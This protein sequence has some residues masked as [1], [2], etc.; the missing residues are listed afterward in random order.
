MNEKG[1]IVMSCLNGNRLQ[2]VKHIF[3]VM[4]SAFAL[5]LVFSGCTSPLYP[6]YN[7]LDSS[8]FILT[9]KGILEGK[10]CYVDLFDHKGPVLFWLEALGYAMGGRTGVCI[11]QSIFFGIDIL[12]LEKIVKSFEAKPLLPLLGFATV[13]FYCFSHGNLTEE[14]SMPFILIAVYCEVL[15]LKSNKAEHPPI[16]A[17]AYGII[18][19]ILAFLRL[20]NAITMC[21]LIVCTGIALIAAKKWKN[22]IANLLAGLLGIAVAALPIC[23]Y[24][25][26]NNALYD[27]LYA[28]FLYNL[29]YAKES[30][31][32]AIFS[33]E[34]P[35][36]IVMYAPG[37]FATAVF[38][39][40]G[41]RTKSRLYFSLLSATAVTYAM[42]VYTNVYV[43][44]FTLGA[45]LF[46]IAIAVAL[47][48]ADVKNIL[49]F[50]KSKKIAAISATLIVTIFALFSAYSVGAPIY[51]T[52]IS[53][54][55]NQ[56]YNQTHESMQIIPQDERNSVIGFGVLADFYVNADITPCYKYYTLQKWWT[57]EQR[58]VYGEFLEYVKNDEPLWIVTNVGEDDREMLNLLENYTIVVQD[59]YYTYYRLNKR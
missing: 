32:S 35:F 57:T 43:H 53:G 29:I 54:I 18:I 31:H 58:N 55:S 6:H 17:F 52:Y 16:L 19:G 13:F 30:T 38:A 39:I 40:A 33:A 15:F 28:T 8:I 24:Y 14:L 49:S 21:V 12:V 11:L 23:W 22:I 41:K 45:P 48:D 9:G 2:S 42:L 59:D 46:A 10:M 51:K 7:C 4:L 50:V 25:Y 36:Y 37:V 1:E 5:M 20:N 3:L 47:P 27:M 44:Y 56:Q 26:A 34:L